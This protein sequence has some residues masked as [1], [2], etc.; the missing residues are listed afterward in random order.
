MS[1][2]EGPITSAL[3]E[4]AEQATAP[5]LRAE[6]AWRAGRRRRW[7]PV[8]ASAATIAA[9]AVLAPLA[10]LGHQAAGPPGPHQ[11][12]RPG[13]A[14]YL[15]AAGLT[16][17][18]VRW[19][20]GRGHAITGILILDSPA[21]A[22][23]HQRLSARQWSFTGTRSGPDL[24]LTRASTTI[25][26]TVSHRTLI[27]HLLPQ[28][29]KIPLRTLT[30]AGVTRYH[31]AVAALRAT[32]RNDNTAARAAQQERARTSDS[33]KATVPPPAVAPAATRAPGSSSASPR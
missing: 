21:G 22:A 28:R 13:Q 11:R 31:A 3:R 33:A 19:Q 18:Y 17:I 10:V 29:G 8:A 5:R 15:S 6:A 20:P 24:T 25:H 16:V 27:L 7:A 32:I 23:P 14:S 9:A 26:A 1:G 30:P 12:P 4:I 2:T